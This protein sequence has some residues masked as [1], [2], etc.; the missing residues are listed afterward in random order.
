MCPK[1][2]LTMEIHA[3]FFALKSVRYVSAPISIQQVTVE[4]CVETHVHVALSV[5]VA[6]C[7]QISGS[8]YKLQ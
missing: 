6:R 7:N 5:T 4:K 3:S 2:V 1:H 8:L